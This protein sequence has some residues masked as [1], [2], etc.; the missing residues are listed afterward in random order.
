MSLLHNQGYGRRDSTTPLIWLPKQARQPLPASM[1]PKQKPSLKSRSRMAH[2]SPSP[3]RITQRWLPKRLLQAQGYYGGATHIWVPKITASPSINQAST[4]H[5][6][7]LSQK[8]VHHDNQRNPPSISSIRR[9]PKQLLQAQGYYAGNKQILIP[10]QKPRQTT[11][12]SA[13]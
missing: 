2:P 7:H 13:L 6:P 3:Q 1:V 5:L 12:P 8:P 9:V 4:P 10:K 11:V